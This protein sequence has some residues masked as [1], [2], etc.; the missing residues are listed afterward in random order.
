VVEDNPDARDILAVLL[1]TKGYTVDT[2]DDGREAVE[3][4]QNDCPDLILSDINMPNLDGIE[5]VRILR[6]HPECDK[7]PILIMS[8]YSS[9]Q[10]DKAIEVGANDAMAKPLDFDLLIKAIHRLLE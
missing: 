3:L 10:I 5:M 6:Q 8:A 9:G 2:A 4:V 7:V 1:R